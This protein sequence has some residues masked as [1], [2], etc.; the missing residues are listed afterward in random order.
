MS[1]RAWR[2]GA[3][4]GGVGIV[5]VLLALFLPGPP[6]RTDDTVAHLTATFVEKRRLFLVD[7][8]VAAIGALAFIWFLAPLH[9]FLSRDR[10][11]RGLAA[12]AVVGG[13]LAMTLIL[14]GVAVTS[15]L[16]LNAAGMDDAT[17]VRAFADTTNVLIELGK[18]GL[19]AMILASVAAAAGRPEIPRPAAHL[20]DCAAVLLI[21]SAL[22]P[23]LF[24]HGIL[25]FGGGVEV[26]AALPAAL[27][28]SWLSYALTRSGPAAAP[29]AEADPS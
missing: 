20:G 11:R 19:A 25:Q 14:I 29:A 16:V 18:F 9:D 28:L 7:T 2:R 26:A 3:A 12:V 1:E 17:V 4:M 23:L 27:W 21:V 22:P 24:D 6:P 13:A 5:L 10:D 8:W 15:G